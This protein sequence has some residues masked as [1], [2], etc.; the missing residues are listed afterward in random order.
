M[1]DQPERIEGRRLRIALTPAE[2]D[3]TTWAQV[4]PSEF[5][6]AKRQ[7]FEKRRQAIIS[8][9][10]GER[11]SSIVKRL[12]ISE[13]EIRR[14]RNRCLERHPDGRIWGF[15][16]LVPGVHQI[17]YVRIA[18]PKPAQGTKRRGYVGM[19][20]RFLNL[21]KDTITKPLYLYALKKRRAGAAESLITGESTF[22]Y[23]ISLCRKAKIPSSEYP[24]DTK[25]KAREALRRRMK[26]LFKSDFYAAVRAVAGNEAARSTRS[27]TGHYR[28]R[29]GEIPCQRV[30]FDGHALDGVF[31]IKVPHPNGGHIPFLVEHP[32]LL[33]IFDVRSRAVLGWCVCFNEQY[34][35]GDV[36]KCIKKSIVPW[37]RSVLTIPGLKFHPEAGM[38][39]ELIPE[40][41]WAVWS[42]AEYD[43]LTSHD[44][45]SVRRLLKDVVDC[46]LNP[47]AVSFPERR[48]IL[49]RFFKL[50]EER[51]I[52]RL[53]N[54][55]GSHPRDKRK[56]NPAKAATA[57]HLTADHLLEL[58][59][60][61]ISDYNST[62]TSALGYRSP[63]EQLRFDIQEDKK[64][65]RLLP[66]ADRPRLKYFGH[67]HTRTVVGNPET[68]RRP[69]IEFFEERYTSKVLAESPEL[70]GKKLK[71]DVDEDDIST[72]F[73]SYPDGTELGVLE[74]T[75]RWRGQPHSLLT[76]K[77]VN[78]RKYL[79]T[80]HQTA[81]GATDPIH[82]FMEGMGKIARE[83]RKS[84][85]HYD[86]Q[87]R[88]ANLP[89]N[90]HPEH[91]KAAPSKAFSIP[92][93]PPREMRSKKKAFTY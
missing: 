80:A 87:R 69:Y 45:K 56:N 82:T 53:P 3:T 39:S 49:E 25:S 64:D 61:C 33:V 8:Y 51:Y 76:R 19:L 63:L 26:R 1:N 88:Q 66:P 41:R 32:W 43:N 77:A 89:Q 36:L 13:W 86:A 2:T 6:K 17:D 48:A 46:S 20:S 34:A 74:P 70:I 47:G 4:D 57:Y 93:L 22:S 62:P 5:S 79:K 60:V 9:M 38:P 35:Q 30:Q 24:W 29:V 71:L 75:G 23:F 90:Y 27:Q 78:R 11:V 37:K 42:V 16:A 92:P 7:K 73:A 15:R 52:H 31:I 40:M 58:V 12:G 81:E 65:V 21:H 55:T 68:G 59:E 10:A 91:I 83:S 18:D 72:L 85:V 28:L 44:A 50:L 84:A 54:T 14:L 67:V